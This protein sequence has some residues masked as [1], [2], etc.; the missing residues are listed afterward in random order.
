MTGCCALNWSLPAARFSH[1][2][3]GP[4]WPPLFAY[5]SK[6]GLGIQSPRLMDSYARG[7][8]PGRHRG[9]TPTN[10]NLFEAAAHD[11]DD[12]VAAEGS[13]RH[14][15]ADELKAFHGGFA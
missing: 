7:F 2:R 10:D 15:Y 5:E 11:G 13:L 9:L 12:F 6:V 8:K 1:R 14:G 4:Q 3:G